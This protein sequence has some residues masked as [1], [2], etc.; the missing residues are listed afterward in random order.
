MCSEVHRIYATQKVLREET[1]S[2]LILDS[3]ITHTNKLQINVLKQ[4]FP[5]MP[6]GRFPLH[7]QNFTSRTIISFVF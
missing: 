4:K 1:L 5:H 6:K 3:H 7:G 2:V